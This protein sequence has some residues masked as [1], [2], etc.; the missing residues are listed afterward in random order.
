MSNI[1]CAIDFS[2]QSNA[3]LAHAVGLAKRLGAKVLAVHAWQLPVYAV[4]DGVAVF[5]PEVVAEITT[6]LQKQV[7]ATLEAHRVDGV[8]IEGKLVA[9]APVEATLEVAKEAGADY[10]VIGTHGRTGV[11]RFVLGSVAERMVRLS[12]VPV[13]VV[14][15]KS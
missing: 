10:V 13:I 9:G 2:E 1:V 15:T 14:P 8:T 6:G 7:A 11:A 5:G 3:A 12:T 4:P